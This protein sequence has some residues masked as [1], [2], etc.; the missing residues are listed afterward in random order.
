MRKLFVR[1]SLLFFCL[2]ALGL[3]LFGAAPKYMPYFILASMLCVWW[4][5][6]D[7]AADYALQLFLRYMVTPGGV[8]WEWIMAPVST[9]VTIRYG[10]TAWETPDA[11]LK[12]LRFLILT[13]GMLLAGYSS[14]LARDRR[15]AAEREQQSAIG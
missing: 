1:L 4:I 15:F 6:M 3:A 2:T 12:M 7:S 14:T 13:T 10:V 11:V 9:L 8:R 5:I